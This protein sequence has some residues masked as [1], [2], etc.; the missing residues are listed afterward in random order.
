MGERGS[1]EGAA[2]AS[3]RAGK[4]VEHVF[5]LGRVEDFFAHGGVVELAADFREELDVRAGARVGRKGHDENFRGLAVERSEIRAAFFQAIAAMRVSTMSVFPC[6]MA[7]PF[8]MPVDILRSRSMTAF[9][10]S[11]FSL[12]LPA[13]VRKS[14]IS[15]MMPSF[16]LFFRSSRIV[17]LDSVFLRFILQ[18][19]SKNRIMPL[20]QESG[21]H[22]IA[23]EAHG[24]FD[25]MA[26]HMEGSH[27]PIMGRAYPVSGAQDI[28]GYGRFSALHISGGVL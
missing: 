12:I 19:L 28:A 22:H 9:S 13:A 27:D 1:R 24:I 25:G 7:M 26:T 21:Q 8:C 11:F 6:G 15:S 3:D 14:I 5:R 16:V 10:A 2:S 23:C 18:T 4:G 20:I 17:S